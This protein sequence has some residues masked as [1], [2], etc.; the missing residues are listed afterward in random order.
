MTRFKNTVK[1]ASAPPHIAERGFVRL[2]IMSD[3]H[4]G[5]SGFEVPSTDADI[6]VLAGD[7]NRPQ[8]AVAWARNIDKPVLYV[9]G[10][11][12]FY[13]GNLRDTVPAL[14]HHAQDSRIQILDNDETVLYGLRFLGSTLWSSFDLDGPGAAREHAIA[15]A[16]GFI[17]DFSR[18]GSA[19]NPGAPFSPDEM[20]AL[21]ARNR[22]W[23]QE[24]LDQ[25]AVE[26]TVVITHHA[27][28]R[29]SIHPRFAGS[30]LNACF[31]SDS[32]HLLDGRRAF[33]WIHGHTH[34]SF[35]YAVNGTRVLCNPR[36]YPMNGAI[37]NDA[38]NPAFTVD[39]PLRRMPA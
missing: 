15:E 36:G 9:P 25:P 19:D 17:R 23:L 32:E 4:L 34:N 18:I 11:H 10:N 2:Q 22:S 31:V 30:P 27:P 3:L 29:R 20:E 1:P 26:N 39:V 13:G 12:E 8:Q 28:S 37:E 6:V 14:R 5:Q 24:R 35:D 38:F 21:F 33:L 16:L 7:I